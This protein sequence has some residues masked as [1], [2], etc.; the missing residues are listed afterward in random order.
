ML[1]MVRVWISDSEHLQEINPLDLFSFCGELL[2][3]DLQL[4]P[5]YQLDR[6]YKLLDRFRPKDVTVDLT[7]L[8]PLHVP[9][10]GYC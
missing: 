2:I 10:E 6:L 8:V 3:N 5:V 9:D 4:C 7:S 1:S